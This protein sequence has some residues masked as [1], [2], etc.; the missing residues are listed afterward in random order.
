MKGI[1]LVNLGSPD[2]PSQNDVKKY[3]DE[4]LM[5]PLVIDKPYLLRAILVKGFILRSRPANTSAAYDKIWT[6][7]GSPLIA[8][9]KNQTEAL[10]KVLDMPVALGMRYG[11]LSIEKGL[12]ELAEMCVTE[13]LVIPLYPQF[14]MSSTQTVMNKCKELSCNFPQMTLQVLPPFYNN[15][16]YIDALAKSIEQETTDDPI[17]H[18]LFSYHG[19]PERHIYKTDSTGSHCAINS[20]CCD[21][22][23][24]TSDAHEYCYRHQCFN[25]TKQIVKRLGLIKGSYTIA[26]QSRLGRDEW[27]KPYSA[28]TI[29]NLPSEGVKN[30]TVV[31]PAFV[32][33][34]L[35]TLEE[36]NMENR[37]T[38]LDAGGQTFKFIPCLNENDLW[39][40][41]LESWCLSW[42]ENNLRT[43]SI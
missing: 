11:S 30:L 16:L 27:L 37:Q 40:E 6:K 2:S 31:T 8:I 19:L 1:L 7:E 18:I 25:T 20:I 22:E 28:E 23:K 14:A 42:S 5:D 12:K 34:C 33:D 10:S 13:T 15:N 21:E 3:L 9:S 35:E 39:I 26:F 32:S 24:V 4:F 41:A 17:E 29:E 38:F 36:M 43:F